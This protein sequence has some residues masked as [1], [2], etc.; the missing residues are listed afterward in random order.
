MFFLKFAWTKVT[1]SV[2]KTGGGRGQ[3]HIWT[4][5][6]ISGVFLGW[7]PLACL[8]LKLQ[9][10]SVCF[11]VSDNA[12]FFNDARWRL[13]GKDVFLTGTWCFV[14]LNRE[15]QFQ[16]NTYSLLLLLNTRT[17]GAW[18]CSRGL[19]RR[20]ASLLGWKSSL[21][22]LFRKKFHK[23]FFEKIY[24]NQNSVDW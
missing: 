24:I 9:Y 14:H 4:M 12:I 15:Q 3:V 22:K 10:W 21:S 13:L 6:K 18:R 11:S 23:Y 2:S 5:S 20:A 7:L 19:Y 8:V 17:W 16:A 1:P